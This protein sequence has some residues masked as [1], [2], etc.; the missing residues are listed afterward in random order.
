MEMN[1]AFGVGMSLV[2]ATAA[3]GQL[4][5]PPSSKEKDRVTAPT[6]VAPVQPEP[7]ARPAPPPPRPQL[8]VPDIVL[9][10]EEGKI[11]RRDIEE[12]IDLVAFQAS[13]LFT[14]ATWERCRPLV[15][16]WLQDVDARVVENL[17]LVLEVD[18]GFFDRL[19]INDRPSVQYAS[20][21]IKPLTYNTQLSKYLLDKGVLSR[22]QYDHANK[23]VSKHDNMVFVASMEDPAIKNATDPSQRAGAMAR[24]MFLSS[25]REVKRAFTRLVRATA[26]DFDKVVAE[27]K[28]PITGLNK[29]AVATIRSTGSS[30]Q[31]KMDAVRSLLKSMEFFDAQRLIAATAKL[32][33]APEPTWTPKPEAAAAP[34]AGDDSEQR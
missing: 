32:H 22:A 19:D 15:A 6:P 7:A 29:D 2:V 31:A 26:K 4:A 34:H 8:A 30:E 3:S 25:T 27:A 21:L 11:V 20:E 23:I 28:L 1:K 9:R 17:D 24:H 10:D 12:S 13:E 5:P 14:N 18:G 33:P 16:A